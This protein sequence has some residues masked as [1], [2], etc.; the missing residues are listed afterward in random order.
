MPAA[1]VTSVNGSGRRL[2][3]LSHHLARRLGGEGGLFARVGRT[4]EQQHRRQHHHRYRR[5]DQQGAAEG[6]GDDLVV[7]GNELFVVS[8]RSGEVIW[9]L[10]LS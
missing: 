2:D 6:V 7:F 8:G 9:D 10:Y 5:H 3:G 4:A 1:A